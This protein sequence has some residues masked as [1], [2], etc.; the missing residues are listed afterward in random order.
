[1]PTIK[2][3]SKNETLTGSRSAETAESA[4]LEPGVAGR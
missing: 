3:T 1:M 4:R 2:G